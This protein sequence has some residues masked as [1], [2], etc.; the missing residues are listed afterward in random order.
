LREL[1][2]AKVALT[3]AQAAERDSVS[4]RSSLDMARAATGAIVAAAKVTVGR[5][6]RL[7]KEA[8]DLLK[9]QTEVAQAAA[10]KAAAA[11]DPDVK[12]TLQ[13]QAAEAASEQAGL[14]KLVSERTIRNKAY[15]DQLAKDQA[16]ANR[17]AAK[18]GAT[19]ANIDKSILV[20][21]GSVRDVQ[22]IEAKI[23]ACAAEKAA[24]EAQAAQKTLATATAA[25]IACAKKCEAEKDPAKKKPLQIAADK[26]AAAKLVAEKTHAAKKV[27]AEAAAAK[28]AA[29]EKTLRQ[30]VA[31]AA[32]DTQGWNVTELGAIQQRLRT[33]TATA[34][35]LAKQ[36]AAE[37][38][39]A[40]KEP[41]QIAADKAA[42][43]KI[44]AEKA[45]AK[46]QA[47]VEADVPLVYSLRVAAIGGMK[48]LSPDAWNYEKARH[49]L[50]RAGFGGTPQEV[51]KLH[52]MGL[53]KAVDH[54]VYFY[55]QPAADAPFDAVPPPAVD[56]LKAKQR[57]GTAKNRAFAAQPRAAAYGAQ[58]D[59]LVRWWLKRMV[60]SPRP[61]QEKLTLFWHGH[62]ATQASVVKNSYATYH[63]NQLLRESAAGNFGTLLYGIVHDPQMIRYLD[64]NSNVK[65]HANENLARE[66][67]E[68]F[69]MGASQGYNEV[70]VREAARALTGY[71]FDAQSGQ[72]RYIG[73]SHDETPKSVFGRKG[74]WTGDDLVKLILEQPSTSR[75]ISRKI[76]EFFAYE[77]PGEQTVEQLSAVLRENNFELAP[78]LKNM[79]LSEQFYGS[80]SMGRQIKSP[81]QLAVGTL[82]AMGVKQVADASMLHATTTKMGQRLF[83]PPDVKGWRAGRSW[84]NSNR[85]FVRYNSVSQLVRTVP[86]PG[87]AKGVDIVALVEAGG[88]KSC[89]EI[90]D[91]LI[92]TCF[93]TPLPAEKRA[94]LIK[95]AK[96]VPPHDQWAKQR[97]AV[98]AKLQSLVV[99]MTSSP[100]YHL[101]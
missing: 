3:E 90:V 89:E 36:A 7:L 44:E 15:R 50:V 94:E 69:A 101:N 33:K 57:I 71:G 41:L 10:E 2:T 51:Q 40:K 75:F 73:A 32:M 55:R 58:Q 5:S 20:T 21:W 96:D 95:F 100:D 85:V 47:V 56:P 77:D 91:H 80:R 16:V 74:N 24:G 65:G 83:E 31:I 29:A 12:K 53:Y 61:L 18:F 19:Q 1:A 52:E 60:E 62:F 88:C 45:V 68:L 27:A 8:Q 66:I 64:N 63:H 49:L 76:F 13:Q 46:Q 72:F 81:M 99:L 34:A 26:A 23:D 98:N 70:D 35:A 9:Q 82:R 86:Q 48:P 79:F 97:A 59:K 39:P 6:D 84:I 14:E 28:V 25:A 4:A 37:K 42:A 93:A 17:A 30:T 54:L 43:E 22:A 38:D 11:T 78:L 87:G 67:M 92:M